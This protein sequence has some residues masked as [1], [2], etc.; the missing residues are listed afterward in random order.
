MVRLRAVAAVVVFMAAFAI[1]AQGT[2]ERALADLVVDGDPYG[3][4]EFIVGSDGAVFISTSLLAESLRDVLKPELF[5]TLSSADRLATIAEWSVF[6]IQISY[7]SESLV[8]SVKLRPSIIKPAILSA[9]E[10][11][12]VRHGQ[13]KFANSP[14]SATV[15]L[16]ADLSPT[17]TWEGSY[18]WSAMGHAS[19]SIYIFGLV[20]EGDGSASIN[21]RGSTMD[22]NSAHLVYDFPSGGFSL[23]AG[24]VS[25]NPVSFQPGQQMYGIVVGRQDGMPGS[26]NSYGTVRGVFEIMSRAKVKVYVDGIQTRQITLSTGTY[27]LS[28]LA[29][30]TGLNEVVLDI[31]ETGYKPRRLVL[32][33]PFDQEIIGQGLWDYSIA[34][35]TLKENYSKPLA[36]GHLAYGVL[37]NFVL[38]LDAHA[39]PLVFMGGA[40]ALAATPLGTLGLVGDL[41]NNP[42]KFLNFS[43]AT[44]AYRAFWRFSSFFSLYIPRLGL[45]LDAKGP[46][47]PR[48]AT[49][50]TQSARS[51]DLS[52]QLGQNLPAGLGSFSLNGEIGAG[53]YSLASL[54]TWSA[55]IGYSLPQASSTTISFTG[56]YNWTRASGGSPRATIMLIVSPSDRRGLTYQRNILSGSDSVNL[57]FS[58]GENGSA[59]LQ[60][61]N[62]VGSFGDAQIS[63]SANGRSALAGVSGLVSVSPPSPTAKGNIQGSLGLTSSL[64]YA[65][66]YFGM[67]GSSSSALALLVPGPNLKGQPVEVRPD[68]GSAAQSSGGMTSVISGLVPY[69]PFV[70][71]VEMP[72]SS[73]DM[74]PEPLSLELSPSYRSV[75]IVRIKMASA[76]TVR[77]I[78]VDEKG[79]PLANQ[80]GDLADY[81]DRS[82]NFG[83]SFSDEKG[84]FEF[85]GIPAGSMVITWGGGY[86]SRITVPE[87]GPGSVFD[88]GTIVAKKLA[89]DG[90]RS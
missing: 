17:L 24:I 61:Q 83:A 2:T 28:D 39:D 8:L 58:L 76:V 9:R 10:A 55:S 77:G 65:D 41:A 1:G 68:F 56:G 71:S 73:P 21:P 20:L 54:S 32:G 57:G 38:G 82:R 78:L 89:A 67:T 74:R 15:A 11:A 19:P 62:L 3:S 43:Q 79:K 14:F 6:G 35:G 81:K 50:G 90:D 88:L 22:W 23:K 34:A 18:D 69:Q 70:A 51:V 27:H 75:A 37:P 66:G 40:S 33:I 47:F 85:F 45:A 64:V 59:T 26:L 29:L 46:V 4:V 49:A 30:S 16:S 80:L 53:S 48:L 72:T 13:E 36:T 25:N 87:G 84:L 44:Y 12:S 86:E 7:D 52:A 42:A 63:T 60:A 5:K 31:A